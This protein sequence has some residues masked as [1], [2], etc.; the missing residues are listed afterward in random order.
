MLRKAIGC[1]IITLSY[2]CIFYIVAISFVTDPINLFNLEN[3][4]ILGVCAI[5]NWLGKRLIAPSAEE[6]L[7]KDTRKPVLYLRSFLSDTDQSLLHRELFT[8]GG[9]PEEELVNLCQKVGPCIALGKPGEKIP[10]L[11]AARLYV[12]DEK[13]QETIVDY[14]Q[15]SQLVVLRVGSTEGLIWEINTI[16]ETLNPQ[17]LLLFLAEKKATIRKKIYEQFVTITSSYFPKPLPDF[18]ENGYFIGFDQNW[19]PK[20]YEIPK[21]FALSKFNF[22]NKI[23]SSFSSIVDSEIQVDSIDRTLPPSTSSSGT[24]NDL[25]AAGEFP[26]KKSIIF[27]LIVLAII[28]ALGFY[29]FI[30]LPQKN[31]VR[32]VVRQKTCLQ[33]MRIIEGAI[34]MWEMDKDSDQEGLESGL[35]GTYGRD[36]GIPGPI[37]QALVPGHIKNIPQCGEKGEYHYEKGNNVV[38]CT[39]HGTIDD[40]RIP[41]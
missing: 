14:L 29:F 37:G 5:I 32:I 30:A 34:M 24:L 13:W 9:S 40:P 33:N 26:P 28:L 15:K 11:G 2:F 23:R 3:L 27:P 39:V 31:R 25:S 12:E 7:D 19:N 18:Q 21:G 20:F 4:L 22:S 36:N 16:I 6:I 17:K 1:I 8:S 35:I 10:S 41:H 38:F